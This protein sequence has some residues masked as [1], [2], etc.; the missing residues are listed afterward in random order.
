MDG[1]VN[2]ENRFRDSSLE[3]DLVIWFREF[4]LRLE[5]RLWGR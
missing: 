2:R 4:T 3:Y 5:A 1:A